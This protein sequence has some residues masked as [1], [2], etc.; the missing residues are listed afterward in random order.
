[1]PEGQVLVGA[2]Y[3][4][5][6]TCNGGTVLR[7]LLRAGRPPWRPRRQERRPRRPPSSLSAH[8]RLVAYLAPSAQHIAALTLQGWWLERLWHRERERA[9]RKRA[10]GPEF[11]THRQLWRDPPDVVKVEA[12]VKIQSCWRGSCGREKATRARERNRAAARIQGMFRMWRATQQTQRLRQKRVSR[13]TLAVYIRVVLASRKL[14]FRWMLR[15]TVEKSAAKFSAVLKGRQARTELR[16]QRRAA[17]IVQHAW[18]KFGSQLRQKRIATKRKRAAQVIQRA[19]R[20]RRGRVV[21]RR[22]RREMGRMHVNATRIQSVV[23]GYQ[24]RGRLHL[25]R[26]M[27]CVIQRAFRVHFAIVRTRRQRSWIK[28]ARKIQ[29]W[30]RFSM[31]QKRAV[32]RYL[33]AQKL[34]AG[35]RGFLCR[36]KLRRECVAAK[37]IQRAW[38]AK[39]A[40]KFVRLLRSNLFA[41]AAVVIQAPMRGAVTRQR[42]RRQHRAARR[43]QRFVRGRLHNQRQR[44]A[45]MVQRMWRGVYQRRLARSFAAQRT[46]HRTIVREE[47]AAQIQRWWRGRWVKLLLYRRQDMAIKIQTLVRRRQARGVAGEKRL[48]FNSAAAKFQ[49]CWWGWY[50][51]WINGRGGRKEKRLR[52]AAAVAVQR[53]FR[54]YLARNSR[55]RKAAAATAIQTFWRFQKRM[56][57]RFLRHTRR[58]NAAAR[59]QRCWRWYYSVQQ[60]KLTLLQQQAAATLI[61]RNARGRSA[62]RRASQKRQRKRAQEIAEEKLQAKRRL[63]N[64]A[65]RIQSV[66]RGRSSRKWLAEFLAGTEGLSRPLMRFPTIDWYSPLAS[67]RN[68]AVPPDISEQQLTQHGEEALIRAGLPT[69]NYPVLSPP[70]L[71]S[72]GVA[73]SSTP[74]A[75]VRASEGHNLAATLP[76]LGTA[77]FAG[78]AMP[79]RAATPD[80]P[81]PAVP[82]AAQPDTAEMTLGAYTQLGITASWSAM[83]V[84][85]VTAAWAA[86][87]VASPGGNQGLVDPATSPAARLLMTRADAPVSLGQELS[88]TRDALSATIH[89]AHWQL[90]QVNHH[91]FVH[92]AERRR[93]EQVREHRRKELGAQSAEGRKQRDADAV[94]AA[95][96]RG[97]SG[98]TERMVLEETLQ[99]GQVHEDERIARAGLATA[100]HDSRT[101]IGPQPSRR[102]QRLG[103]LITPLDTADKKRQRGNEGYLRRL[104]EGSSAKDPLRVLDLSG[105]RLTDVSGHAV[106]RALDGN[107]CL[108]SLTLDNNKLGDASCVALAHALRRNAALQRVSLR[109]NPITDA[110]ATE[111]LQAV[112]QRLSDGQ[113]PVEV[114]LEGTL[115]DADIQALFR[116]VA[117]GREPDDVIARVRRSSAARSGAA[118]DARPAAIDDH[119]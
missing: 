42:L 52:R 23:R 75:A 98:S 20:G 67:G 87:S 93:M 119:G 97:L 11:E 89:Q 55:R 18:R 40:R 61:Q 92:Q 116:A 41:G 10:V 85:G 96:L 36:T 111:L 24:W 17:G 66:W 80:A 62:R 30:W 72:P 22:R 91:L 56:V 19:W 31:W 4:R 50:G 3:A 1:M 7:D 26:N 2:C 64:A 21:A 86:D 118:A 102:R 81:P 34:Q 115:T 108:T 33:S 84:T 99:R 88:H 78:S 73:T 69:V 59:I 12:A 77:E 60:R 16:R 13:L 57:A 29:H 14:L 5:L 110:G 76:A 113:E 39:A 95:K 45:G 105:Q 48:M 112:R 109:R 106:I 117:P 38:R 44:A 83:P 94:V 46:E 68:L 82:M 28:N 103:G 79:P 43:I 49:R 63:N 9:R 58:T 51:P 114:D 6:L 100:A 90:M 65:A 71:H 54:G 104:L 37:C 8:P 53:F 70:R 47:A 27:V 74:G 15:R 101:H 25:M 35:I 107:D 32:K